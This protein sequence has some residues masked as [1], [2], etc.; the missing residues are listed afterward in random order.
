[1]AEVQFVLVR[2]ENDWRKVGEYLAKQ[3]S[4]V[5][6]TTSK[7]SKT[8]E[9][10]FSRAQELVE[11]NDERLAE[12]MSCSL[13]AVYQERLYSLVMTREPG[14]T[15]LS[16]VEVIPNQRLQAIPDTMVSKVI[17][18]IL[19]EYEERVEGVLKEVRHFFQVDHA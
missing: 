9:E 15:H 13:A 10:A 4:T 14:Q 16:I 18:Q 3:M 6:V 11:T 2:E 12:V 8:P 5:P 17:P 7:Y 19:P 1:M